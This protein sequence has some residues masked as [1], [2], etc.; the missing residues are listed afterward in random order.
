[1]QFISRH[2]KPDHTVDQNR[3]GDWVD[4]YSMDTEGKEAKA[5]PSTEVAPSF[6]LPPSTVTSTRIRSVFAIIVFV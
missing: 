5:T 6:Q 2:L 1:M 3:Y 4:A